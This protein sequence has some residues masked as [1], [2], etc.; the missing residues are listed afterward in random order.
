M[1]HICLP[2][3]SAT[4]RQINYGSTLNTKQ[5][6]CCLDMCMYFSTA[7]KR[8]SRTTEKLV[9]CRNARQ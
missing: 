4:L 5:S 8:V 1:L 6:Q 7:I 2:L 3:C 9:T